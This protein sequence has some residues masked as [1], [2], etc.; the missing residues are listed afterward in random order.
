MKTKRRGP[1]MQITFISFRS[2]IG[3]CTI[4]HS[5]LS[6]CIDI[7][8]DIVTNDCIVYTWMFLRKLSKVRCIKARFHF[9]DI[10]T[11]K[12]LLF[13]KFRTR[14]H[15]VHNAYAS[16]FSVRNR[17]IRMEHFVNYI[18]E[19][20]YIFGYR[21]LFVRHTYSDTANVYF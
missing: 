21:R 12:T 10:D 6:V 14:T 4:G 7:L 11:L 9:R 15:R 20:K 8:T 13:K 1:I 5:V 19:I 16:L 3:D 17:K 18:R 2:F